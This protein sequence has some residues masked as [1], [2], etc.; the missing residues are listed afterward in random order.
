MRKNLIVSNEWFF[1][2]KNQSSSE[3]NIGSRGFD[4]DSLHEYIERATALRNKVSSQP[5][6]QNK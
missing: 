1:G 2:K 3:N 4:E 5:T 6:I